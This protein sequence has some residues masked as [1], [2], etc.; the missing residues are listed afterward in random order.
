MKCRNAD[1]HRAPWPRS[2]C[3]FQVTVARSGVA[4][5]TC[6]C[7][8]TPSHGVRHHAGRRRN[9]AQR[10]APLKAARCHA[11][12]AI[13]L[14]SGRSADAPGCFDPPFPEPSLNFG[15]ARFEKVR[16]DARVLAQLI[17]EVCREDNCCR[18]IACRYWHRNLSRFIIQHMPT[19]WMAGVTALAELCTGRGTSW[20]SAKPDKTTKV[21]NTNK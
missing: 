4:A 6:G 19:E 10:T 12:A 7:A 13:C 18:S 5:H 17:L 11:R 20:S 21:K 8:P 14:R 9:P 15:L 3:S 2:S 16:D 1:T